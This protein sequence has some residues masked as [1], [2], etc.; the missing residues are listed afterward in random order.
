[1]FQVLAGSYQ[2]TRTDGHPDVDRTVAKR[3]TTILTLFHL[4]TKR[5][6]RYRFCPVAVDACFLKVHELRAHPALMEIPTCAT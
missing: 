4:R 6:V 5:Q 2:G 1:M 3:M